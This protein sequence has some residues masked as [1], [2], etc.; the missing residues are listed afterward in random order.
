[1]LYIYDGSFKGLLTAVF[2]VFKNKDFDC[3]LASADICAEMPGRKID[4][5]EDK[6]KRVLEGCRKKISEAFIRDIYYIYLSDMPEAGTLIKDYITEGIRRGRCIRTMYGDPSVKRALDMRSK[7]KA[8][9][10]LFKGITRFNKFNGIYIAD[11]RP[12][13][14]ILPILCPHFKRRLANEKWIICDTKR[15]KAA[16]HLT[17]DTVFADVDDICTDSFRC[18]E[19]DD[20]W[21]AFYKSIAIETRRN[22]RLRRNYM[23]VRYWNN[24]TELKDN[25]QI[26]FSDL[27]K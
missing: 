12:D 5:D 13:H 21:T 17:A 16:L 14:N 4:T 1:M 9:N 25:G 22:E 11:I 6:F 24:M 26:S 23:P 7:V 2:F 15:G 20:A 3:V 8:E 18:D 27:N 19:I 10:H